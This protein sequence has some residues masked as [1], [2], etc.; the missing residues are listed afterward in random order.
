MEDLPSFFAGLARTWLTGDLDSLIGIYVHPL[1]V[2]TAG[3][4]RIEPTPEATRAS[5]TERRRKAIA[6]GTR[7]ILTDVLEVGEMSEDRRP[8]LVEW[9]YLDDMARTIGRSE[10]RYYCREGSDGARRIEMIEF[11]TLAFRGND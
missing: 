10:I 7:D 11:V 8:V 9:L 3:Q 1:P 2:F 4:W 5:I 6:A